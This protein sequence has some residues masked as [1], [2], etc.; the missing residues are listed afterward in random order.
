MENYNYSLCGFLCLVSRWYLDDTRLVDDPSRPV[1]LFHDANDP[2]LVAL[3][4]LD[5]LAVGGGLFARQTD[6][7]A[8]RRLGGMSLEQLEH[9]AASLGHCGHLGYDGKIVDNEGDFLLLVRG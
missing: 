7:Q 3:L 4:P 8:T 1:A 2:G 5:V 9:V 6:E